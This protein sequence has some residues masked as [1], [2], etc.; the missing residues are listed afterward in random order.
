[1][2]RSILGVF[3]LLIAISEILPSY[4]ILE[5]LKSGKSDDPEY[6]M[7][8]LGMHVMFV[9]SFGIAGLW[10]LKKQVAAVRDKARKE[11]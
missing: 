11:G 1:M 2:I 3:L 10:L 7:W 9:I 8:K 6:W 4:L 5:G